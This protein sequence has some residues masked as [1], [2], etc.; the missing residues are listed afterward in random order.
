MMQNARQSLERKGDGWGLG[1]GSCAICT[2]GLRRLH[3]EK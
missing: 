2:W 1:G 3:S